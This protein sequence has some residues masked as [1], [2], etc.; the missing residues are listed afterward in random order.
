VAAAVSALVPLGLALRAVARTPPAAALTD[1]DLQTAYRL[2][3]SSVGPRGTPVRIEITDGGRWPAAAG[4]GLELVRH[5]HPI[6][7]EPPWTLLFG[8]NR[9]ATGREPVA[10]VVAGLDPR[11][12]P[13]SAHAAMLGRAGPEYLFVRLPRT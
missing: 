10:I 12:W 9:R 3:A 4:V 6:R 2:V 8:D 7:V 13:P 11:T 5:G 1:R